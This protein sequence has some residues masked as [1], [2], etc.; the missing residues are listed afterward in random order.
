M[1]VFKVKSHFDQSLTTLDDLYTLGG[2]ELYPLFD[3]LHF[4]LDQMKEGGMLGEGKF[5][6]LK[7]L[8]TEKIT[9]YL[10][11]FYQAAEAKTQFNIVPYYENMSLHDLE[12]TCGVL[13]VIFEAGSLFKFS[14]PT[15]MVIKSSEIIFKGRTS[16]KLNFAELR[17]ET[18]RMIRH[19]LN[20][21]VLFTFEIFE[22]SDPEYID[23]EFKFTYHSKDSGYYMINNPEQMSFVFDSFVKK[24]VLNSSEA[25]MKGKHEVY[26]IDKNC[27]LK[28]FSNKSIKQ[29][30]DSSVELPFDGTTILHFPFLFRPL[31]LI[32]EG[33]EKV[34]SSL[35]TTKAEQDLSQEKQG[36]SDWDGVAESAFE[37]MN[38]PKN[39]AL[40]LDLF[41]LMRK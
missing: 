24:F 37:A 9:G 35:R 28:T 11:Q 22:L 10:D 20:K 2:M 41:H 5:P 8:F 7:K 14:G 15:K 33:K 29:V 25:M 40:Y 38:A 23:L 3:R 19:F 34:P 4:H 36:N 6:E 16:S 27:T 32:I 1:D 31:S 17:E 26:L 12:T 21:K 18:Y 13:P 39:K 30:F